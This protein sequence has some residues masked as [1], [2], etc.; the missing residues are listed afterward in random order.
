LQAIIDK[1]KDKVKIPLEQFPSIQSMQKPKYNHK[2]N[3]NNSSYKSHRER[4]GDNVATSNK[5]NSSFVN[6][7]QIMNQPH[8]NPMQSSSL[9]N[10][11]RQHYKTSSNLIPDNIG[12]Q[13]IEHQKQY[14]R[15]YME[16]Q[17]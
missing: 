7:Q 14:R 12:E 13:L 6:F 9:T 8:M 2:K 3:C 15:A 4:E 10:S 17:N 5:L 1:N 16:N 11:R